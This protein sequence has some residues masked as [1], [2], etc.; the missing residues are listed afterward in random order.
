MDSPDTMASSIPL[1]RIGEALDIVKTLHFLMESDY[2]T[3][4]VIR[5]D[6]GRMLQ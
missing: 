6:G 3:G 2:I 5:V 1:K 4:Q